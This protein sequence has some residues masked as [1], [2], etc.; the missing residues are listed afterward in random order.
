[1]KVVILA[2]GLGTRL[3]EETQILP[4]P[5][6]E[7][8]GKPIIWYIMK[9]Y[10][11]FGF[12]D[13]VICLGYKGYVIKEYFFNYFLHKND[14]TINL[15]NNQLEYHGHKSEPWKITLVDT[16]QDTQTGGRLKK[17]Q[18]FLGK[19]RFF[20]T[21]GDG[22]SDVNIPLLLE[23]HIA[24]KKIA[25]LTAVEPAP[26]W[27]VLEKKGDEVIGFLEKAKD[28]QLLING[29]FFVFEPEIFSYI[30]GPL[31]PLEKEPLEQLTTERQLNSYRHEGF[32]KA[33]DTLRDKM[34]IEALFAKDHY[35]FKTTKA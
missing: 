17:V 33:M 28:S 35:F 1:M 30:K 26:R 18:K 9:W 34:E 4:K 16:G 20:L 19:E 6:V 5:M 2:G 15:T 12:N 14:I 8:G 25:T 29:G 10:S 31:T 11:L 24:H 21:Y 32:W 23:N 3:S 13:F 27:G 7:I 22:I